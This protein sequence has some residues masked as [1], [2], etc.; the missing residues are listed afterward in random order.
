MEELK[1]DFLV[2]GSGVAGLYTAIRAATH[3]SVTLVTKGELLESNTW[4]AQGGIAA[5][6]GRED[7]PLAHLQDTLQAG[8]GLCVED[9]VAVLVAEGPHR[10]YD[11]INIGTHF[12][13]DASG[14]L[15]LGKEAAHSMRRIVHARGDAT[16]AEVAES[17]ANFATQAEGLRILKGYLALDLLLTDEG[18]AGAVLLS[19]TGDLLR[20]E[21]RG[22]VLATGGCGQVYLNTTNPS[23][24]TGDGLAMAARA[25]ATLLDMEFVQFHPT[26]LSIAE[27]PMPLVSEAVRGEG[28][29]LV[30]EQGDR[31][32]PAIHDWAELAPRDVVARAIF[33]QMQ[34]G[35]RVYLDATHLGERFPI[36]FPNIYQLC[37]E[38]GV[39]ARSE[40]I[41]VAPAAHFMMGGVETNTDGQ[42]SVP[43]LYAC[44]EVACTGV[45]GANRL[46]SNSLLE[47]MVFA[48]RVAQS[49]KKL[50]EL[51]APTSAAVPAT[52]LTMKP[53]TEQQAEVAQLAQ[54]IRTI[55]WDYA[56]IVRS[57]SGLEQAQAELAQVKANPL[58]QTY[59]VVNMCLVAE[60]IV[61]AALTRLESR[62]GH[63]RQDYPKE[64]SYWAD[65]RVALTPDGARVVHLVHK[66]SVDKAVPKLESLCEK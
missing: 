51:S 30:N 19:P 61:K 10:I 48:E 27:N 46:A 35:H 23:V 17:L 52:K 64:D 16:G 41:P 54:R 3:G 25:G 34:Q 18:C 36:R 60:Q 7:S 38:R 32:M 15:V 26:A 65:K 47:G 5:A 53:T 12:D 14:E 56:G 24:A 58:A 57:G 49:L 45:H 59:P 9:A 1:T 43:H 42:T 2:I 20:C 29:L 28:A 13:R 8:A 50:P 63:Y 31:F 62:G 6:L 39:D 55:M 66:Q 44:G 40:L 33:H 11:L 4:Y 21:A 37:R 22:T